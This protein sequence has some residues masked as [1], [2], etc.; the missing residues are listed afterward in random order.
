MATT[1]R[2]TTHE[3][4]ARTRLTVHAQDFIIYTHPWSAKD[5]GLFV[6]LAALS[7]HGPLPNNAK[8]LGKLAGVQARVILKAWPDIGRYWCVTPDGLVLHPDSPVTASLISTARVSLRH[9]L[10]RLVAFWGRAC[11]YCGDRPVERLA[12]EHIVPRARGGSDDLT[13]LT[14]A[15]QPCN[16]RKGVKTAAEFGFPHV[17]DRAQRIQ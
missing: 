12:I 6:T 1:Q 11:V 2:T 10:A 3:L 5:T 7:A 8:A 4:L 15:C 13:N 16:S 17:H 14:L 9:Y